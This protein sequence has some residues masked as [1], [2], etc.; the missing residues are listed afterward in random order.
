[1]TSV[2]IRLPP[3]IARRVEDLVPVMQ[4]ETPHRVSLQSAVVALVEIGLRRWRPST[5]VGRPTTPW[6]AED[7]IELRKRLGLSQEELA[8]RLGVSFA[9]V[10]RWENGKSKPQA[11]ARMALDSLRSGDPVPP[12]RI[13]R[14][15]GRSASKDPL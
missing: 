1:M 3:E 11:A 12:T 14:G 4:A 10:N 13:R 2:V 6:P 15:P 5:P 7:V 9:S 8:A